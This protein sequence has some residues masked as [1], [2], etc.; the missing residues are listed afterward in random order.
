MVILNGKHGMACD[1]NIYE[2][3]SCVFSFTFLIGDYVINVNKSTIL[4]CITYVLTA[5][6]VYRPV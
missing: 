3:I 4:Y 6:V 1:K 2:A 5:N